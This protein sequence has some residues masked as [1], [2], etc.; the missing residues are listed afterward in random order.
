MT[1][2]FVLEQVENYDKE[3]NYLSKLEKDDLVKILIKRT[4][5]VYGDEI[6][7]PITIGLLKG[8]INEIIEFM[9]FYDLIIIED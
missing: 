5:L 4:K 7:I 6:S 2:S 8:T 1:E 9:K 3:V